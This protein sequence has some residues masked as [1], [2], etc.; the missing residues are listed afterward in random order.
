MHNI[1]PYI[2]TP[3][4]YS[5][6]FWLTIDI[7]LPFF[8]ESIIDEQLNSTYVIHDT[9]GKIV[10]S[11]RAEVGSDDVVYIGPVAVAPSHQVGRTNNAVDAQERSTFL[12]AK[13]RSP[14]KLFAAFGFRVDKIRQTGSPPFVGGKQI[15]PTHSAFTMLQNFPI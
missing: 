2:P 1:I 11:V 7:E 13:C 5:Q 8:T 10:G 9:S 4:G 3:Y 14:K 12:S 6:F 15:H